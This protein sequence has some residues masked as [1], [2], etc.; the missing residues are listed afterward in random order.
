MQR[1]VRSTR[2]GKVVSRPLNASAA[3]LAATAR[4][5]EQ[6]AT[7]RQLARTSEP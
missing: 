2:L 4:V 6:Q 7:R 5:V 1:L 3:Q